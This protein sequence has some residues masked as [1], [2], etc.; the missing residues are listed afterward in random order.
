[1]DVRRRYEK[2]FADLAEVL[3]YCDEVHF[4]DNE[5]G[6]EEVAIYRNGDVIPQGEHLPKWLH[7]FMAYQE[8]TAR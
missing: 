8:E 3:P 2:R 4:Y 1:E 6:F 5:N 7:D